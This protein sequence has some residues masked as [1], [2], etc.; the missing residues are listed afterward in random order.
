MIL[1]VTV[2]NFMGPQSQYLWSKLKPFLNKGLAL[3][4]NELQEG[5]G[6]EKGHR[7]RSASGIHLLSLG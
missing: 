2:T 1:L 7:E 3:Q 6:R 4:E 5:S